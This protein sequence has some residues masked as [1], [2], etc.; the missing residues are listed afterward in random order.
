[1]KNIKFTFLSIL[2][3]FSVTVSLTSCGGED[4]DPQPSTDFE[5]ADLNG[6][7]NFVSIDGISGSQATVCGARPNGM[8]SLLNVDSDAKV[9]DFYNG[10]TGVPTLLGLNVTNISQIDENT[11]T[12][13]LKESGTQMFKLQAKKLSDTQ[14]E[15]KILETGGTTG[16]YNELIGKSL[17]LD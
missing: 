14:V 4:E 8:I 12:F 9:L 1:M 15:V 10:C 17:I 16:V 2:F 3:A 13:V 11:F 7:W 6:D 5:L